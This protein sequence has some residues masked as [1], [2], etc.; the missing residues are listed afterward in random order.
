MG[1]DDQKAQCE[2]KF[3]K[4]EVMYCDAAGKNCKKISFT[5]GANDTAFKK[6]LESKGAADLGKSLSQPEL[7]RLL[8][9]MTALERANSTPLLGLDNNTINS[10]YAD[11]LADE[12]IKNA[13]TIDS[14]QEYLDGCA[15]A[16]NASCND[17]D[18]DQAATEQ[19]KLQEKNKQIEED[20][21]DLSEQ[22]ETLM[23]GDVPKVEPGSE[24]P[25]ASCTSTGN[26]RT[27][28][29]RNEAAREQLVKEMGYKCND[30][31]DGTW[32]CNKTEAPGEGG[33]L[34]SIGIR[35]HCADM[36]QTIDTSVRRAGIC[37]CKGTPTRCPN[38]G[39][40]PNCST[41]TP[42]PTQPP[43]N[44]RQ[45]N[46]IQDLMKSLGKMFGGGGVPGGASAPPRPPAQQCSTDSAAYQQQQ[47]QYQQ[48]LQQYNYQLQQYN[49]QRQLAQY[50]STYYGSS[51]SLPPPPMQPQACVPSTGG[52]CKSQPQQPPASS[53]TVGVWRANY[54]GACISNWQC[55]P[56]QNTTTPET[57]KAEL[58]CE[59][60]VA[61][62][63]MTLNISYSCSSG[64]AAGNGFTTTGQSGSATAII[65]SPPAGTNTA[66]YSLTC[67]NEGKTAG[68]Q[69]SVQVGRP[70]IILVANPKT[71]RKNE[72]SL[73]GW[74]TAGMKS[75]VISSSEQADFTAR[76]APN[77]STTGAATT[78]PVTSDARFLLHCETVAGGTKEATAT[79]RILP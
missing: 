25:D 14:L 11:A 61:D 1:T 71:V 68:A 33:V 56:N 55:I 28:F 37:P 49:Y 64:T 19:Q 74:T 17:G 45:Q 29:A 70:S 22:R 72:I 5:P 57:P 51:A 39:T 60:K 10:A 53:C 12:Q 62:V 77:T 38:G 79:V 41:F 67:T 65:A 66:S 54:A 58:S 9:D 69:C 59:P 36:G 26:V 16:A 3:P 73:I 18:L 20:L 46:P 75:C 13:Q 21:R 4:C 63:G 15:R 31:G 40:P 8:A 27:C 76:N 48:Q 7:G 24:E 23:P 47:Q 32:A 34:C 43:P 6:A 35:D 52:Q 50:N 78:S 2:Q 30:A 44:T 42:P